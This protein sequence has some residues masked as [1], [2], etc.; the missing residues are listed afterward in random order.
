MARRGRA[1][2]AGASAPLVTELYMA[3]G[4]VSEED[5]VHGV[6]L[7]RRNVQLN[8]LFELVF[9]EAFVRLRLELLGLCEL[10]TKSAHACTTRLTA[11]SHIQPSLG[12]A[13]VV[14]RG[15]AGAD[16]RHGHDG[17]GRAAGGVPTCSGVTSRGEATSVVASLSASDMGTPGSFTRQWRRRIERCVTV[18]R[19]THELGELGKRKKK[20]AHCDHGATV[21]GSNSD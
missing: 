11:R 7:E 19:G 10:L 21:Q 16:R 6:Q 9:L 8:R 12:E 4:A 1:R 20:N 3:E 13:A 17:R 5:V 18:L 14:R 15:N 2:G